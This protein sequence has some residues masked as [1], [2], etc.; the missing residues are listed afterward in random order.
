MVIY[1][2]TSLS[3]AE[4]NDKQEEEVN[5]MN[6]KEAAETNRHNQQQTPM[7]N[8]ESPPRS[9]PRDRPSKT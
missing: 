4:E 3:V 5:C 8:L 9:W 6:S 1:I 2:H 7:A